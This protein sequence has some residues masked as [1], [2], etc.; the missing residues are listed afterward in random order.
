MWFV[1]SKRIGAL[2][3]KSA[4]L[5]TLLVSTLGAS[6]PA[7]TEPELETPR[8]FYNAGV[9]KLADKKYKEAEALLET[10]VRLQ[11]ERVLSPG[12]YNLGHT[13][14]LQGLEELKKGPSSSSTLQTSQATLAMGAEA[15]RAADEALQS[16]LV[17]QMVQ[18]YMRGRGTRKELKAA[19]EAVKKALAAHEITLKKWQ[20]AAG[21]FGSAFE[22]DPKNKRAQENEDITNR[23]IARLVDSL[24]ELQQMASMLGESREELKQKMKQLKGQIPEPDMPPG[25]EGDEDEEDQDQ[26]KDGPEEG[27]QETGQKGNDEKE[28]RLTPEQAAWLLEGYRL[29]SERRLPMGQNSQTQPKDKDRRDW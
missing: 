19:A 8:D 26:K 17:A 24:R 21:D 23:H 2:R 25:A 22:L 15:I 7:V 1:D 10:A 11:S 14:F 9:R 12:L 20:R 13:R 16:R 18:A 27:E 3:W 4:A 6:G 29:D 5:G 28:M